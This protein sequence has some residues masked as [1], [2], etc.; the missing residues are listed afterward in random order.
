MS[1]QIKSNQVDF[2]GNVRQCWTEAGYNSEFTVKPATVL[3]P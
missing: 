2:D 1:N 3:K